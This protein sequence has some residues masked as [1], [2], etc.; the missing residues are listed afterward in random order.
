M[1]Y[2]FYGTDIQT[3]IKK[4]RKLVSDLQVKHSD[5]Y[6]GEFTSDNFS[7]SIIDEYT[8]GQGLFYGKSILFI[9]RISEKKEV[10]ELFLD[11][12][13]DVKG[14][15]N[16]FILLEGKL[17]ADT[18]RKIGKYADKTLVSDVKADDSMSRKEF[19]IFALADAIGSRDRN[20][21]WSIYREAVDNGMEIESILGTIFWQL[22][23]MIIAMSVSTVKD[24]GLNPFVYNK[25]KRYAENFSRD[26]LQN[27]FDKVVD[28]Y[29][30]SHR[31]IVNGEV[32]LERLLLS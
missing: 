24:S 16:V 22:K 14:S 28:I 4:A 17:N 31:G 18:K 7:S 11:R 9:N 23:S 20:K 26:E 29:H 19:N 25:S 30:D 13:E 6:F 12:I 1:L 27:M 21:S 10:L 3:S 5:A 32:E 2:A 8:Q 15:D